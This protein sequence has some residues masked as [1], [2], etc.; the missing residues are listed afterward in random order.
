MSKKAIALRV[1]M[2]GLGLSLLALAG[3]H[4]NGSKKTN[5][6]AFVLNLIDDTSDTS[7]PVGINGKEFKFKDDA[8]AFD[9]L[10]DAP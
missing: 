2:V 7:E 10:F 8:H 3:C 6:N 4:D 1:G 9:G 5:F